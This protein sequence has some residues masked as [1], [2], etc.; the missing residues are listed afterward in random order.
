M[1]TE[2]TQLYPLVEITLL[3]EDRLTDLVAE[4]IDVAIRVAHLDDS[5]LVITQLADNPRCGSRPYLARAGTPTTPDDLT[6][7]ACVLWTRN[8]RV[9]NEW[10]FTSAQGETAQVHVQGPIHINDGMALAASVCSGA[11]VAVLDRAL[12][13]QELANGELVFAAAGVPTTTRPAHSR[14]L[15]GKAMAGLE[16]CRHVCGVH[17]AQIQ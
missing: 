5:S 9:Y 12:V 17:Q 8:Q 13:E 6:Q 16:Q 3:V 2:F 1:I 4:Q 11:G 10:T 14:E 15:P 7:H